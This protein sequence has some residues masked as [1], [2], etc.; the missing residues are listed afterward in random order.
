MVTNTREALVPAKSPYL[1]LSLACTT[2]MVHSCEVERKF[3]SLSLLI[4][5]N[6]CTS[7]WATKVEQMMLLRV[8]HE[9]RSQVHAFKGITLKWEALVVEVTVAVEK[10]Q[11]AVA[12]QIFL[13]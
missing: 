11:T 4:I 13:K 7:M 10:I 2:Q 5:G 8:N 3:S 1:T 6:L 12:S 9:S